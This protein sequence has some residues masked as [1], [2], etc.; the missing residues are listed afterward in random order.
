MIALT[1]R[2]ST[3]R[4]PDLDQLRFIG[5]INNYFCPIKELGHG[6]YGVVTECRP[7]ELGTAL[8]SPLRAPPTVAL[9]CVP[10]SDTGT[11]K[12]I[13]NELLIF[14]SLQQLPCRLRG[15]L[16]YYMA[17]RTTSHIYLVTAVAPGDEL[18]YMAL[19]GSLTVSEKIRIL[20]EVTLIVDEW[21]TAKYIHRDLKP[22]NLRVTKHNDGELTVT[23]VDYGFALSQAQ[24]EAYPDQCSDVG[25]L[26][27]R[28]PQVKVG[29][30]DSM[31]LADIWALGQ[32]IY[33]VLT[34]L[35]LYFS[36]GPGGLAPSFHSAQALPLRKVGTP[37]SVIHMLMALTDPHRQPDRRPVISDILEALDKGLVELG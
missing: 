31:R 28:D 27:M 30:Y 37:E 5:D 17:L 7:T 13:C 16:T 6:R 15:S 10:I 1:E 34:G 26:N 9:K 25:T 32:M 36:Y 2:M 33:S 23:L 4:P 20:K 11:Q 12:V 24:C 19:D 29:Q 35:T 18:F 21:H 14:Q 3:L 8:W 22:E